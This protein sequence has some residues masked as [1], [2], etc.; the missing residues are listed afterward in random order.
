MQD[1]VSCRVAAD[2]ALRHRAGVEADLPLPAN[3]R[4][5]DVA[6]AAHAT[7]VKAEGCNLAP[8]RLDW[9]PVARATLQRL[10][11]WVVTNAAPQPAHAAAT[12]QGRSHS[13]P[14]AEEPA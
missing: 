7:V 3:V 10:D 11:Q 8:G 12:C 5:Y 4:M 9:A 2:P 6:G 13:A 14:S 1:E